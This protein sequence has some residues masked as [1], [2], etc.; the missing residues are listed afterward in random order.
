MARA[1]ALDKWRTQP[2]GGEV[3]PELWDCLWDQPDCA[4]KGQPFSQCVGY[5]HASWLMNTGVFRRSLASP[6]RERALAGA[7]QLGYELFVSSA[8]LAVQKNGGLLVSVRIRDTGAAPFYYAWPV[9]LGLLNPQGR[10]AAVWQTGWQLPCVQ[11]GAG[12]VEFHQLQ[13]NPEIP[14]GNYR[15][16]LR[17]ANPLASAPP[18]RFA[19]RNQDRDLPGWLTLGEPTMGHSETPA[20]QMSPSRRGAAT[21]N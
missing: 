9:E 7:R 6:Q 19:D 14:A 1:G 3:R 20:P 8:A 21:P 17:V 12:P 15:V 2:V 4:P 11:P 16:L 13:S 18:L 10:L 5:T